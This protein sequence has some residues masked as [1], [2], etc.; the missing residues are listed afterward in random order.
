M[1]PPLPP[2]LLLLLLLEDNARGSEHPPTEYAEHLAGVFS[3]VHSHEA[4]VEIDGSSDLL[5]RTR[6][7]ARRSTRTSG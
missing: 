6:G 4:I 2:S 3:I 5:C 7:L 1:P